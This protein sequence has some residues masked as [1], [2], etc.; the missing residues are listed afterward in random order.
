MCDGG[1]GSYLWCDIPCS[2][3]PINSFSDII[4]SYNSCDIFLTILVL[5]LLSFITIGLPL[6]YPYY[7]REK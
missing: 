3:S 5:M 7:M 2:V 6:I 4:I 1:C